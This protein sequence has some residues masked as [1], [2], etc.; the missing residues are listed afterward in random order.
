MHFLLSKV[1]LTV[2]VVELTTVDTGLETFIGPVAVLV[3]VVVTVCVVVTGFSTT[4][5]G[6]TDRA[7]LLTFGSI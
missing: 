5:D 3:T 4:F 2:L 6:G 1:K 7:L